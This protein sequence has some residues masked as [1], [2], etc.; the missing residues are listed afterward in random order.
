MHVKGSAEHRQGYRHERPVGGAR[1]ARFAASSAEERSS[2][3]FAG[4]RSR[5]AEDC[6]ILPRRCYTAPWT[7]HPP[8]DSRASLDS[9]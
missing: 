5:K 6:P 1:P 8:K 4:E 3:A 2:S 9:S 7:V